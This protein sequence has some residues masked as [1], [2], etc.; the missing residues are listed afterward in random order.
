MTLDRFERREVLRAFRSLAAILDD[1]LSEVDLN[2]DFHQRLTIRP[3][4]CPECRAD[5]ID[6]RADLPTSRPS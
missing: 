3:V 6:A 4:E 1:R 5:K 2:C